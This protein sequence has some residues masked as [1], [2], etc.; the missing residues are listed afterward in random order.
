MTGSP[1]SRR[2][3]VPVRHEADTLLEYLLALLRARSGFLVIGAHPERLTEEHRLGRPPP[4][5]PAP[6]LQRVRTGAGVYRGS[7][8]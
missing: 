7:V 8:S 4:D 6:I 5:P 2:D 1:P 3:Q